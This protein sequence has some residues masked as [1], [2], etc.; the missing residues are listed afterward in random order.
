MFVNQFLTFCLLY[1]VGIMK[2]VDV[3]FYQASVLW[4][5]R[6]DQRV[7]VSIPQC[8]S[9]RIASSAKVIKLRRPL[10][11]GIDISVK[12][13]EKKALEL[14]DED[15]SRKIR[16]VDL[17]ARE[18]QFHECCRSQYLTKRAPQRNEATVSSIKM[19]LIQQAFACC[20]RPY[21]GRSYAKGSGYQTR[22]SYKCIQ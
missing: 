9:A 16:G 19:E 6:L 21:Q 3:C 22:R 4:K 7:S 18:A 10:E 5:I 12:N 14:D 17:F 8:C 11:R 1:V 15:L 2:T 20:S 13:I